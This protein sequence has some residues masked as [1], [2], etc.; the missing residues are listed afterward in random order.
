MARHKNLET[1]AGKKLH[2]EKFSRILD[3]ALQVFAEKGFNESKISEIAKRADVGDGTIYLYFKNKDDLL[4]SLF[5]TKLEL[6]NRGL[7]QELRQIADVRDRLRHVVR[8]HLRLAIED[9]KLA[10]FITIELRRSAKF[11]KDYAKAQ[12][13]AYLDQWVQILR[14]GQASGEF[15]SDIR[16]GIFKHFLFGALDQVCV[17]WVNN[18]DRRPEDLNEIG[19]QLIELMLTALNAK[20]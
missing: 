3:A 2:A 12:F 4:I 19:D 10:A 7:Q 13:A 5:E 18:L 9:P 20:S 14:D 17:T 8:Y 11:V 16:V 1:E 6:I 15:R